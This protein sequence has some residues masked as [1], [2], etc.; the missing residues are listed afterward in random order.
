MECQSVKTWQ[1]LESAAAHCAAK[2]VQV[3]QYVAD[4][5]FDVLPKCLSRESR[6][7]HWCIHGWS[8]ASSNPETQTRGCLT[9]P[10]RDKSL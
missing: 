7:R 9:V 10:H 2:I 1:F 3:K 5:V 4:F 8:D 6:K